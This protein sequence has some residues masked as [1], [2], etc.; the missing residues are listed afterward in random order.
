M[1]HRRQSGFSLVEL[2]VALALAGIFAASLFRVFPAQQKIFQ[3][4]EDG[5]E[6][7][8]NLRAALSLIVEN[9]RMAGYDP[10]SNSPRAF[11]FVSS[12]TNAANIAYNPSTGVVFTANY[13]NRATPAAAS[14]FL[15]FKLNVST[16]GAAL[17]TADNVLRM[18][19]CP[20]GTCSW[21]P[22]ADNV[23]AIGFA[24]AFDSN[25]DG[26]LDSGGTNPYWAI[27]GDNDGLLDT[28]LDTDGSGEVDSAD[29]SGGASFGSTVSMD[30]VRAV[31]VWILG[32]SSHQDK[33]FR[34]NKTFVVGNQ[35][36][37]P[38]DRYRHRLVTTS[39]RCR[40]MGLL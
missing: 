20:G 40:N 4:Q 18:Y 8:Q 35:R 30:D 31:K 23:V 34:E 16:A 27:D 37:T 15:G 24:F 6:M 33:E 32:R 10:L 21:Q 39:V 11:G 7:G 2:L 26:R 38:N 22:L 1:A 17:V 29:A 5:V 13:S 3:S 28:N 36:I 14:D 12:S 19:S 9:I 25:G